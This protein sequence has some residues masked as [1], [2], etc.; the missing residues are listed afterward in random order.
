MA[1]PRQPIETNP[2]G[3]SRVHL[4]KPIVSPPKMGRPEKIATGFAAHKDETFDI[5]FWEH[6]EK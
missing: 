4:A 5:G 2:Q 6:P 3:H 1:V